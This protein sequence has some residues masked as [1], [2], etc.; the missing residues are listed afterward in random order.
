MLLA[1]ALCFNVYAAG[2]GTTETTTDCGKAVDGTRQDVVCKDKD[3]RP[4][5]KGKKA[6]EQPSKTTG[7]EI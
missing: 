2:D 6:G 5:C 1:L 4:T 3:P 7:S